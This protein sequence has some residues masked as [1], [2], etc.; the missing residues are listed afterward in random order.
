[1]ETVMASNPYR[2]PAQAGSEPA[3]AATRASLELT[4]VAGFAWLVT[5]VRVAVGVA[6]AEAASRELDLAWLIL[7]LAPVVIWV[8]LQARRAPR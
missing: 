8:E 7:F 3:P 4:V 5:L 1:M 6:R 2:V